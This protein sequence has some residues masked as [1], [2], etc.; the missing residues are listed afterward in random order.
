MSMMPAAAGQ[1]AA[2]YCTWS[3]SSC[4]PA[5]LKKINNVLCFA[6]QVLFF[7]PTATSPHV[8]RRVSRSVAGPGLAVSSVIASRSPGTK[9]TSLAETLVFLP[10]FLQNSRFQTPRDVSQPC[11][12]EQSRGQA[13]L[14]CLG[15]A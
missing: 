10:C 1:P 9:L 3:R 8:V 13:L 15:S 14:V 4:N 12:G 6:P 11:Q 7:V 2:F 5:L